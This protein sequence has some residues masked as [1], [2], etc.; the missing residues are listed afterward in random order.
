MKLSVY[1]RNY[2]FYGW[3][4]LG[5]LI[6]FGGIS[7]H[8][9]GRPV[10]PHLNTVRMFVDPDVRVTHDGDV[11]HM[12]TYVSASA[13]NSDLLLAGGE[14]I[15][16]GRR[17]NASQAQIYRS[18]DGGARWSPVLLPDEVNGGWDNAIGSGPDGSAYFV[19]SNSERGLTVYRTNDGG[20]TWA[21]T[22]LQEARGWD[23]PHIA[24][25][26]T[27]SA[28]RGS[29]YVAG[30]ADDGV[31]LVKS[32]DGGKAF[33]SPIMACPHPKGWNAATTVSPLVL[34]DGTLIVPC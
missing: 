1:A 15:F 9:Q 33:S 2:R 29:F 11:V 16:P 5:L 25:D 26:T 14:V 10:D 28:F 8:G 3:L 31:R 21:S 22:V 4:A 17:A 12:E 30:E 7:T 19:T 13:T 24:I 34:R 23:R 18:A 27:A 6:G 20:V 32:R